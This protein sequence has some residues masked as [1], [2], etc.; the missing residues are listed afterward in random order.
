MALT[1]RVPKTYPELSRRVALEMA[2]E[3]ARARGHESYELRRATTRIERVDGPVSLEYVVQFP[4]AS[5]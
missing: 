3:I 5:S 2:R 4:D 1:V